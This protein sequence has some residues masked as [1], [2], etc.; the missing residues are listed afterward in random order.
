M[1]ISLA[2]LFLLCWAILVTG[3]YLSVRVQHRKFVLMT[4][5]VLR[6]VADNKAS[7]VVEDDKVTVKGEF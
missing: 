5:A 2:E 7:I 4:D 1:T 3:F 6:A